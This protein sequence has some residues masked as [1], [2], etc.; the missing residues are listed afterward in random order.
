MSTTVFCDESGFTGEFLLDPRQR[1]FSSASVAIEPEEANEIV[2]RV[3]KDYRIQGNELKGR[4]L[5]GFARGRR[6]I[7]RVIDDIGPRAQIV[8]HHNRI[9]VSRK[10]L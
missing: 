2:A 4:R 5:L 6:A 7:L 9:R 10:V 3:V 1:Y 8:V